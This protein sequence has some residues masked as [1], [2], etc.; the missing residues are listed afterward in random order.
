[1]VAESGFQISK[2]QEQILINQETHSMDRFIA[3]AFTIA[4]HPI[5]RLK[6]VFK[7]QYIRGIGEFLCYLTKNDRKTKL[8]FEIWCNSINDWIPS[9]A[10]RFTYDFDSLKDGLAVNRDDQS[11]NLMRRSFLFD[12]FYLLEKSKPG[13][14]TNAYTFLLDKVGGYFTK[15]DLKYAFEYFRGNNKG[16]KFSKILRN[17]R[18]E[19]AD[20]INR[21]IRRVLIVATMSAGKS[22]LVNALVGHPVNQVRATACTSRIHYIYNKPGKE[23]V[24]ASF[25]NNKLLYTE[26]LSLLSTEHI[27][28]VGIHFSSSLSDSRV[29]LIDTP[30]VNFNGDK[31]HG[32]MTRKAIKDNNYDI[33][34]LV[35]NAQQLATEDERDLIKFIGK[36][37]RKKIITVLNQCDSYKSAQDSIEKAL[38]TG[39]AML[40][41]S[42]IK[43]PILIPISAHVAFLCR[44]QELLKDKMD[45]DDAFELDMAKRKMKKPFL[46]LPTYL[47]GVPKDL[48]ITSTLERSGVPYLEFTITQQHI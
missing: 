25:G 16:T 40:K 37:S 15:G 24:M 45:E 8:V 19:S 35:L 1:M 43:N 27:D 31:T 20:F 47:P 41:E 38:L 21:Q 42:G 30:G 46:N 39:K 13:L 36:H 28:S 48:N 14:Y 17:H 12:C 26:D 44:Q 3:Q 6:D 2:V 10:W 34:L 22:T 33:I 5:R 7:V 18:S 23:G 32:E 9:D 4:N 29:C 11:A